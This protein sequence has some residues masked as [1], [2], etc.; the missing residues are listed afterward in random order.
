MPPFAVELHSVR[1]VAT[2]GRW[3]AFAISLLQFVLM[4]LPAVVGKAG[5]VAPDVVDGAQVGVCS[6]FGLCHV[7]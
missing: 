5:P 4:A 1:T 2:N 6:C 3:D 7:F